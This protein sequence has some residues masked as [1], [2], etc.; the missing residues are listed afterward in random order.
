MRGE[1]EIALRESTSRRGSPPHARGAV[2]SFLTAQMQNR[3]TPA[4]AG[5][6]TQKVNM[7]NAQ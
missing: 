6:R 7:H 3:I 1:Q 5:S 2:N 4:C